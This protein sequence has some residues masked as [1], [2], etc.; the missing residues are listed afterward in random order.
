MEQEN[1]IDALGSADEILK[2]DYKS[3]DAN[4]CACANMARARAA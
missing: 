3:I 1:V 4:D 2:I